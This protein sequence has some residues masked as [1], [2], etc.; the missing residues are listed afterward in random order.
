[1]TTI[2]VS[3]AEVAQGILLD[4]NRE[5][6]L[7]ALKE[8]GFVVLQDVVE[9]THLDT[10][11]ERMIA[12][13]ALL[14]QRTDAP[15]NW[16]TGNLQ[17]DPPPFPPYLFADVLLNEQVIAVTRALLGGGV[18][19][20]LYTGNTAM[21]SEDRQPVHADFGQMWPNIEVAHPA[22]RIIVNVPTVDVSPEN[23]ST[24]LWPGT[25]LD[26]ST[27]S[28]T[29]I[30]IPADVLT[31]RRKTAPPIQPNIK[32]GSILLRDQRLW[33]AG[34]PNRTQTPRPM[35]A[36]MHVCGWMESGTPL[37]FPVEY[38]AFFG[39]S[40]LSTAAR[41]V[42]MDSIDHIATPGAYEYE[43]DKSVTK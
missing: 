30:K 27:H 16:N 8:D 6:A 22:A 42:D 23:A 11:H 33:H 38:K 9:T 5:A 12:D 1:M 14:Q 35:I 25:H 15:Y 4:E 7:R 29:D 20:M 32:K 28:D 2:S 31:A 43:A 39:H 24:E 17:Q 36:M 10:L 34:M 18:K 3:P 41:F 26:V 40:I 21:P 19:N 37:T 13:I